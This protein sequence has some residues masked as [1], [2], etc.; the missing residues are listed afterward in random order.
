VQT[1]G[2]EDEGRDAGSGLLLERRD[3][4]AV[5]VQRHPDVAVAQALADDLRMHAGLE[6][7]G[8]VGVAQ[9]V[10]ADSWEPRLPDARAEELRE[11]LG[12]QRPAI[13]AREQ[14][15]LVL[16]G[17]A[18]GE[19]LLGLPRAVGTR[20]YP[21]RPKLDGDRNVD[22]GGPIETSVKRLQTSLTP[23]L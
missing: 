1:L 16:V 7:E 23:R 15:V 4:V 6:G 10:E 9:V 11:T 17:S 22:P 8:G 21:V 20:T 5:D 18:E 3:R 19:L 14:E 2:A 12:V 13:L